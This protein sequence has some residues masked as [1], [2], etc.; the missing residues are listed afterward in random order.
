MQLQSTC[1]QLVG[2]W[3]CTIDFKRKAGF[4]MFKYFKIRYRIKEDLVL[5]NLTFLR[6]GILNLARAYFNISVVV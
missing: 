1:A 2:L 5:Q 3:N 4:Y 6:S